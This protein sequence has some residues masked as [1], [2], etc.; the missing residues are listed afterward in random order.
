MHQSAGELRAADNPRLQ[1]GTQQ[2]MARLL[3]RVADKLGVAIGGTDTEAR[4]LSRQLARTEE[5]HQ[6]LDQVSR[7]LESA[8]RTN[9][10]AADGASTEKA[11]GESGRTGEGRQGAGGSDMSVLREE[12]LRQLRE[13]RSL[14]D[15]LQRQDPGF[16]KS[17]AGFTP[18][19]QGMILSAPGTEGFKQDFSK[20]ESL[21]RQ[22]TLALE[23][24]ESRL[25]K[26]I[27]ANDSKNRLAAGVEDMA[28]A[29]YQTQVDSYF[30][31]IAAGNQQ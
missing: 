16:S 1:A 10:R 22:G 27:R 13:A 20:W 11:K 7:A 14:L 29:E 30:R 18:E 17:G 6:K 3:D 9:G 19:G 24:A 4:K 2:E 8:A 31:A 23:Q 5:V 21:T 26:K 15:D 12:S 28:P 25:S